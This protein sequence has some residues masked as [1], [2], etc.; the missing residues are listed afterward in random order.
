M[1]ARSV[2]ARI[3]LGHEGGG[4]AVGIGH[5]VDHVLLQ[6][7]PVGAL[8]QGGELGADFAL[9]RTSHFVV[10]DFDR[11]AHGFEDERHLAAHVVG[12]VDWGHREVAALDA[13]AVAFVAAVH[14][15]AAVP[16]GFGFVDGIKR[17]VRLGAPAHFVKQEEFWLGTEVGGVAQARLLEVSLGALGDRARVTLVGFA[18]G[19]LDHVADQHQGDFFKEGVDDGAVGVGDQQHVRGFDALPAG[20]R[21]AVKRLTVFELAFVKLGH[22]HRD[23]LPLATGIG[24]T[25][26]NELDFVVFHHVHH[27]CDGLGHQI[28]LVRKGLKSLQS[29]L[30]VSVPTWPQAM[31]TS[32]PILCPLPRRLTRFRRKKAP[33]WACPGCQKGPNASPTA[34]NGHIPTVCQAAQCTFK[35][36]KCTILVNFKSTHQ[37]WAVL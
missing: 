6:K 17:V 12:A 20:N 15:G 30:A 26:V 23:V 8:D 28:L 14:L 36:Q 33:K 10:V 24:E 1:H 9:T 2:V 35:V 25:E 21:R 11:D 29:N 37:F 16:G 5:V 7:G 19:G 22:G 34:L 3:G 32:K 18:V 4:L 27:I 31:G 13:V